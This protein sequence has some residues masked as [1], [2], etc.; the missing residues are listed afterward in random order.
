MAVAVTDS[1]HAGPPSYPKD[2]PRCH[3]RHQQRSHALMVAET[4]ELIRA[5][6]AAPVPALIGPL[7]NEG[8]AKTWTALM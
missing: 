1:V 5:N 6:W 4:Q 8:Q 2:G 7:A 3:P